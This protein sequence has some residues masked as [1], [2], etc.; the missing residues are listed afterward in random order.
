MPAS[1]RILPDLGLVHVRYEGA[2]RLAETA[3]LFAEYAGHPD[4]GAGQKQLVDLS[5]ITSFERDYVTLVQLQAQKA[6]IF[7]SGEGDTMIVYLAPSDMAFDLARLILRSWDGIPG[8]IATA[9]RSE[10]EAL[11]LLGLDGMTLAD[12]ARRPA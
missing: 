11:S 1:F 9:Q 7:P 10:A 4:R 5:A 8:V 6:D 12:L 3:A 2:V